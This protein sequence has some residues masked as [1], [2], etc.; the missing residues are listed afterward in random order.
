MTYEEQKLELREASKAYYTDGSSHMSDAAYDKLLAS[1]AKFE[2]EGNITEDTVGDAI[3][4][5][6]DLKGSTRHSEP[7][8]SLD[9][10]F[11]PA[12]VDKWKASLNTDDVIVEPK[13]DGMAMSIHFNDKG[14][15]VQM[16]TRG[17]G[18]F[19]EDCTKAL[20]LI[21]ESIPVRAF[22]PSHPEARELRPFTGEVRGEVIFSDSQFESASAARVRDGGKPFSNPRNAIA[23]TVNRA[24]QGGSVPNGTKASFVA[25]GV[26]GVTG[27]VAH[28]Q[29]MGVLSQMGFTTALSLLPQDSGQEIPVLGATLGGLVFTPED[30]ES[31]K[32][33]PVKQP[34]WTESKP[35]V[36]FELDG[37]V[38]K[39]DD[40]ETQKEIGNTSRAPRWAKAFKF[41]S[42]TA[43]TKLLNVAWAVGRTGSV[44]P[45]A[46]IE[47]VKVGGINNTSATLHN[48]SEI[49][50]LG[51]M[52]G[53]SVEVSRA[54]EVIP[55]IMR[56]LPDLRDG[57]ETEIVIPTECPNCGETLDDSQARLR[58]PSGGECATG[59][60]LAYAVS[61]DAL[62]IDG[63]GPSVIDKLLDVGLLS[64]VASI[65]DLTEEVMLPIL[66][67]NATK[68]AENIEKAREEATFVRVL[69]SLGVIGTGRTMCKK[70]ANHFEDLD[71]ILNTSTVADMEEVVGKAKG[72]YV[73]WQLLDLRGTLDRLRDH[74][75]SMQI[76]EEDT[77]L[78][79]PLAGLNIVVTG[80]MKKLG[81]RSEVQGNLEALGATIGSSVSAKTNVLLYEGTSSKVTKAEA[82]KAKGSPIKILDEGSFISEYS[83]D[84]S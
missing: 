67:K 56:A 37:L 21:S 65:F 22:L 30:T 79:K 8:L 5:G 71:S 10:L 83:L 77:N 18:E 28:S 82:L 84:I 51:L 23:G 6:A 36:G 55:K 74:G 3:A 53:D 24:A 58:C 2:E 62:D 7:M 72:E 60:K 61:K 81:S 52:L 39:V 59:R 57:S 14:K 42:E 29:A 40:Y 34:D 16:L 27:T 75:L 41:P 31:I 20:S 15:A 4:A 78:P 50:R 38:F 11:T 19:G 44:T 25:Y 49:A 12:E 35:V 64:D 26:V 68:I 46:D 73:W 47:K 43:I 9:N 66:G 17:N 33:L 45:R 48:P 70:I 76:E 13:L 69:I 80:S 63:M 1:V 54:G 32:L